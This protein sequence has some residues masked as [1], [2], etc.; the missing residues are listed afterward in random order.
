VT[1]ARQYTYH[2]LHTLPILIRIIIKANLILL[3]KPLTQI[4]LNTR[5]FKNPLRFATS[6]I[7]NSRNAT[8]GVDFQKPWFLLRAFG[9][10]DFGGV[11]FD[12][13][14][15]ESDADFVAVGRAE[16]VAA[17]VCYFWFKLGE[18]VLTGRS[19]D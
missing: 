7:N 1:C 12:A 3:I 14:F 2:P 18:G 16:G 8:V 17:V 19:R 10:V 13:Q 15:F 9:D 4:Q 5:P 6:P 11:V